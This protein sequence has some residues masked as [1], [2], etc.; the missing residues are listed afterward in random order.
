MR[1]Q[2]LSQIS[3]DDHGISVTHSGLSGAIAVLSVQIAVRYEVRYEVCSMQC[4]M[5]RAE[6]SAL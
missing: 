3:K 2:I 1:G 5:K 6:C 4:G